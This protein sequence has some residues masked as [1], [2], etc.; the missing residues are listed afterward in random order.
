MAREQPLDAVPVELQADQPARRTAVAA[1][2]L[3]RAPADEVAGFS[4]FTSRPRPISNGEYSCS[5]FM[6]VAALV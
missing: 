4:K 6:R 5:A 1:L 2:A 3:E